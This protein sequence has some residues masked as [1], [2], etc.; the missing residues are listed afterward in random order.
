MSEFFSKLK[1]LRLRLIADPAWL[2]RLKVELMIFM[3]KHPVPERHSLIPHPRVFGLSPLG[4]SFVAIILVTGLISAGSGLAAQA[5]PGQ[6]A[7]ALK[8]KVFEPMAS[9]VGGVD[10]ERSAE[11]ALTLANRRLSEVEFLTAKGSADNEMLLTLSKDAE[12]AALRALD[13]LNALR[14]KASAFAVQNISLELATLMRVHSSA[15]VALT[16]RSGDT[17][18]ANLLFGLKDRINHTAELAARVVEGANTFAGLSGGGEFNLE[19][20]AEKLSLAKQSVE[21][22]GAMLDTVT[23]EKAKSKLAKAER[24]LAKARRELKTQAVASALKEAESSLAASVETAMLVDIAAPLRLTVRVREPE[25][26]LESATSSEGV[27]GEA[28]VKTESATSSDETIEL[29]PIESSATSS[30]E[31]ALGK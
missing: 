19:R 10:S 20:A 1:Q 9:L 22:R 29:V 14:P 17:S 5:L 4:W 27:L 11:F 13:A 31:D 23:R 6:P 7:Y 8:R 28:S 24:S 18:A 12:A 16:A 15:L 3:S 25:P 26:P 2:L 30:A 21:A